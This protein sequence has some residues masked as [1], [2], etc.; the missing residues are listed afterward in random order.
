MTSHVIRK[1]EA[2][3]QPVLWDILY[4]ALWDP[5]QAPRRP[6]EVISNPF[7]AAYVKDWGSQPADLGFLAITSGGAV[8]GGLLSRLMLP[9]LEGGAF[10]DCETPQL[11]IAVFPAF[12]NLGIGTSLFKHYL[13]AASKRFP[14]VALGV[15]PEN[16][17]AIRLYQKFGFIQFATGKGGYL[18]MVKHLGGAGWSAPA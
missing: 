4:E 3:D 16:H 6:R 1:A 5:P 13:A 18:N 14:R 8:T 15:H 12:R 9:P 17:T 11:G 2:A 10:Y 7:I